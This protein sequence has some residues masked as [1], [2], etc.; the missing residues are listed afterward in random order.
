MYLYILSKSELNQ[1]YQ[2]ELKTI[3]FLFGMHVETKTIFF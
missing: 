2:T 1:N 3:R